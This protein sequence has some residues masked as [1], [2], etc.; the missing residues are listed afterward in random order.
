MFPKK[1]DK[2]KFRKKRNPNWS[3]AP[4][5]NTFIRI[6]FVSVFNRSSDC[7]SERILK[8]PKVPARQSNAMHSLGLSR[9]ILSTSSAK[10][11][12][13]K[14]IS[15]TEPA[16]MQSAVQLCSTTSFS[17][18]TFRAFKQPPLHLPY[19]PETLR[20]A[21]AESTDAPGRGHHRTGPRPTYNNTLRAAY[22]Q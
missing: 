6:Y 8:V 1:H 20:E 21:S 22:R 3:S 9:A 2:A 18:I 5:H 17:V 12:I 14:M 4:Y 13:A 19:T 16:R 7:N 15:S 11:R 10:A